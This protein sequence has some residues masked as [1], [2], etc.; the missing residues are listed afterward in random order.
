[1]MNKSMIFCYWVFALFTNKYI[2]HFVN[3]KVIRKF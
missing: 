3:E 1:M 2:S